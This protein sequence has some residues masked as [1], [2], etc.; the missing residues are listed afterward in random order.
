MR[1]CNFPVW[2]LPMSLTLINGP[3]RIAIGS[4]SQIC[5]QKF[6]VPRF[7]RDIS[8]RSVIYPT[9]RPSCFRGKPNINVLPTLIIRR[10]I[11]RTIY[12]FATFRFGPLPVSLTLINGPVTIAIGSGPQICLQKSL[13]P[14]FGR[15]I[16]VRSVIYPTGRPSCFRGKPNINVLPTSMIRIRRTICDFATFRFGT[17]PVS[18]TLIRIAI[19]SGPQICL[20]KFLTP[21]FGPDISVRSK[22]NIN[23]LP[24]SMIRIR[25]TILRFCHFPVW[26][27]AG[28]VDAR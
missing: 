28:V 21:R 18:L 23:V 10:R 5:L 12:D 9:G 20:Q 3:V 17:L 24:T 27:L 16:S 7:D 19:G 15:D 25:R 8:V 11:R 4:G 13:T 6:L 14:R 22:P 2:Y 26:Y 1:F